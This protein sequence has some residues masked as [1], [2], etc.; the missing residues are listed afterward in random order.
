MICI[1]MLDFSNMVGILLDKNISKILKYY[2]YIIYI[3]WQI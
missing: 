2:L 1:H 3:L